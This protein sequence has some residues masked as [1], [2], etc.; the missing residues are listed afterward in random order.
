MHW[1]LETF[2]TSNII[3]TSTEK[4]PLSTKSPLNKYGFVGDG[5]PFI[6]NIFSKS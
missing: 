6:L 4:D 3:M 2:H 1:G 5:L